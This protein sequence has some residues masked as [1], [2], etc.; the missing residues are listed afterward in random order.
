[1]QPR[2][3]RAG[4]ALSRTLE[5][6]YRKRFNLAPTDP[7]FLDTTVEQMKVEFWA[8]HYETNKAT[9]EFEDYDFDPQAE[10]RRIEQEA[11]EAERAAAA[12]S[13]GKVTATS[14]AKTADDEW[15]TVIDHKQ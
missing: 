4:K 1:M 7:R 9:E 5:Y 15:V 6:W 14:S 8:A 3:K 12:I 2:V 13:A 11:M 10:V